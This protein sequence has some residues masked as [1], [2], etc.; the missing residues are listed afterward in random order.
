MAVNSRQHG[1]YATIVF[2]VYSL[3]YQSLPAITNKLILSEFWPL[4]GIAIGLGKYF[5]A[6]LIRM[7]EI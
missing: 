2:N 6:Q 7:S 4:I 3:S 1:F 5:I